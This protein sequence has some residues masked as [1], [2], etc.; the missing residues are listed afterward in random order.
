M[1]FHMR[2]TILLPD[3]LYQQVRLAATEDKRTVTAIIEESLRATLRERAQS[4]ERPVYRIDP[5]KGTGVQPG[6]DLDDNSAL[7]DHMD[8]L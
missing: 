8:A 4:P 5:I 7:L 1:L 2:T 6:V 3:D